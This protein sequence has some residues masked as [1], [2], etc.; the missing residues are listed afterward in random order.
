MTTMIRTAAHDDL[1]ALMALYTHLGRNNAERADLRAIE[2]F[3]RIL[4]APGMHLFLLEDNNAVTHSDARR[5]GFARVVLQH[6]VAFAWSAGCYK[7]ML[8]T[9]KAD[10]VAFYEACGFDASEK[11]AL[12]VRRPANA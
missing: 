6:A 5:R 2:T 3:A 4:E 1:P 12:I 9:G 10:N 8:M 7:V 11:H